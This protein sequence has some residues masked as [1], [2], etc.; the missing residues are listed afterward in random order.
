MRNTA[1]LASEENKTFDAI[2]DKGIP[3]THA[4]LHQALQA[5]SAVPCEKTLSQL[6]MPGVEMMW[7]PQGLLLK[8]KGI[9]MTV[10]AANVVNCIH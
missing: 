8:W 3:V 6:K 10:P 4:S 2:F 7:C 1:A 5:T 9:R